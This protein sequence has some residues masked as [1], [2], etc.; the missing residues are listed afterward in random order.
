MKAIL[1]NELGAYKVHNGKTFEVVSLNFMQATLRIGDSNV[2]TPITNLL[3]VDVDAEYQRLYDSANWGTH[4]AA[5][6]MNAL[7]DY[8]D[9]NHIKLT[10][11]TY[12]CPS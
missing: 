9:R 4:G 10:K 5:Y 1:I 7:V 2:D 6:T 12:N 11:P 8:A 3:V